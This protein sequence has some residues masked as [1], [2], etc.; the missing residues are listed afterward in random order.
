LGGLAPCLCEPRAQEL[1]FASCELDSW[2]SFFGSATHRKVWT[3]SF[4]L[5]YLRFMFER[6]LAKGLPEKIG[7]AV[8]IF[9][10]VNSRRDHGGVVFLDLRDRSGVVQVVCSPEQAK[11]IRDEWVLRIEGEVQARPETMVN[12]KLVTGTVEV[13]ARE[14]V[15]LAEAQTPP[16]DVHDDGYAVNEKTRLKYRY[17]DL[18][19]PRLARN[20]RFRAQAVKFIRDFLTARDFV[21]VETPI[22][23]KSTPEG[24][25]DFLVPSRLQPGKFYALP[26]SP[27]QYK[28]LL[29]VAGLE[30]YFQIARCF[31]D[32]D[33]RADR[34]L[35]FTQLD[36]EMSFTDQ[37]EVLSLTEELFTEL[38]ETLTDKKISQKPFPRL[39]YQEAM[40]K[41]GTDAPDLRKNKED[42]DEL[43][44]C[45]VVDFPLFEKDAEGNLAPSH[46]PFTAPKDEDLPLLE[47]DP[48]KVRSW[49]HDLVL[50]GHEI[51]GG[52]IRITNPEVLAR[53]FEILGHSREETQA[54]FGH[55]LEA[56][57]YGVPPHGG[58]AP[59]ID[60]IVALLLGEESIREVMAFPVTSLGTT[61]V[62]SA[63]STADE[64]QLKELGIKTDS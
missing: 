55:L 13:K 54:K 48:S 63:P 46:H 34:Q 61:S 37:E 62:M 51:A 2:A 35:E 41:F 10:W 6:S 1:C 4:I 58:I 14:V 16:F 56:F 43:A 8:N 31:R 24:A 5:C 39:D 27:Q 38:V 42:K 9:G 57:A 45:W 19:R 36:L 40:D 53:V 3:G 25:R 60:R 21:E 33:L 50:N 47:T 59:G 20:I 29:M 26:Q 22:L 23:S 15:V 44:F 52:S 49:Q 7:E 32:E 64:G 12:P 11:E 17:L 30:R 18:R 28:Q